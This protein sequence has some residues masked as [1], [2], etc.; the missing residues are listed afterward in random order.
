MQYSPVS[1]SDTDLDIIFQRYPIGTTS[2]GW[3]YSGFAG[4]KWRVRK[5]SNGNMA[6]APASGIYESGSNANGY[7][8]KYVDGTM[9]CWGGK[10]ATG[11]SNGSTL[12]FTFPVPF[13]SGDYKSIIIQSKMSHAASGGGYTTVVDSSVTPT[14]FTVGIWAPPPSSFINFHAIG[15]WNLSRSV[16][17]P[18]TPVGASTVFAHYRQS[19]AYA[20]GSLQ[21]YDYDELIEDSLGCV[22]TGSS[23]KFTAPVSG[24]YL[25]TATIPTGTSTYSALYKNG[26]L[27]QQFGVFGSNTAMNA[28]PVSAVI[29]LAQ[30]DYI[31]M[32]STYTGSTSSPDRFIQITRLS[33]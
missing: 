7:Y 24:L 27:A 23:W 33:A 11:L 32:R 3:G 17:A 10:A 13:A 20:V 6:E 2:Y 16:A 18:G 1:G 12:G 30:G 9:E 29:R 26:A 14:G 31:D 28:C 5:I 15:K 8:V 19:S 25:V 22:T 21:P 4:V